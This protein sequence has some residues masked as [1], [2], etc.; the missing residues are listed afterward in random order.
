MPDIQLL[1][2]V[3][4]A[5]FYPCCSLYGIVRGGRREESVRE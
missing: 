5:R 3:D 2:A 4:E 1:D